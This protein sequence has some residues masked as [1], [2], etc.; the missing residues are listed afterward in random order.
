MS[1]RSMTSKAHA[2]CLDN[3]GTVY[4][5][6]EELLSSA[7]TS[8]ERR[9]HLWLSPSMSSSI[10]HS[11]SVD[12]AEAH[13]VC[14]YTALVPSVPPNRQLRLPRPPSH[15]YQSKGSSST[16]PRKKRK[17][18]QDDQATLSR[19]DV[20]SHAHHESLKPW[21]GRAIEQVRR[22]W[23][24]SGEREWW[25][26]SQ[27]VQRSIT[28]EDAKGSAADDIAWSEWETELGL[29]LELSGDLDNDAG[30]ECLKGAW[31][32]TRRHLQS[33][34]DKTFVVSDSPKPFSSIFHKPLLNL[35]SEQVELILNLAD[36]P[37]RHVHLPARSGFCLADMSRWSLCGLDKVCTSICLAD[38][39]GTSPDM[40]Y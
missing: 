5:K 34:A 32:Q 1:G 2:F 23:I 18:S 6:I 3:E 33:F 22:P 11:V 7:S 30:P 20:E 10:L 38:G 24:A 19:A 4:H 13:L 31:C 12:G 15:P 9:H 14:P 39:T 40:P 29:L 26:Q 37:A 28:F 8:E 27:A 16:R 25:N 17:T 35:G 36:K 21:L